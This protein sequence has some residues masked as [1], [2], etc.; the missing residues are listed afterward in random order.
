MKSKELVAAR[1]S[2]LAEMGFEGVP[3]N[4]VT[5]HR[6]SNTQ[7]K[8]AIVKAIDYV[9][10][11]AD[12]ASI[13]APLHPRMR[14]KCEQFDVDFS[15]WHIIEPVG[16]LNMSVLLQNCSSVFTDS[17]GLQK[18]AAFFRKKCVTLRDNTEW[19]E[20][21]RSG[22]NRLWTQSDFAPCKTLDEYGDGNAASLIAARLVAHFG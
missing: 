21:I 13:I 5:L 10:R 15:H 12:C 16:F 4:L 14:A 9:D 6:Q 8:E 18:E 19:T 7:D 2:L 11:H 20:T 3:Y 22:W 17:G 1:Q